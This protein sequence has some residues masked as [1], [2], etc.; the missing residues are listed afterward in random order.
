MEILLTL[1]ATSLRP[2]QISTLRFGRALPELWYSTTARSAFCYS[3]QHCKQHETVVTHDATG[4]CN[5]QHT[6]QV[7]TKKR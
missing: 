2:R 6:A 7:T 1:I 4:H 5:F 3:N